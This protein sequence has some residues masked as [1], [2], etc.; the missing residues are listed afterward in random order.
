MEHASQSQSEGLGDG[1]GDTAE[2]LLNA[3]R[4]KPVNV[5]FE[6]TPGTFQPV[7][8]EFRQ[9][10]DKAMR[11]MKQSVDDYCDCSSTVQPRQKI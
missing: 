6:L 5:P 4:S 9:D 1:E 10:Q 3:S 11:V 2:V 8:P 7:N